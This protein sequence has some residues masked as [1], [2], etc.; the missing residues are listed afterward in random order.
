MLV[1]TPEGEKDVQILKPNS[2]EYDV[3]P[4]NYIVPEGEEGQ[5]HA[6]VEIK[7]FSSVDGSR[8]SIPRIQKF[9]QKWF[10]DNGGKEALVRQG[11]DVIVLHDPKA[12]IAK[13]GKKLEAQKAE[14]AQ[15]AAEEKAAAAQAA[16]EAEDAA[17][18]E[19]ISA[20]VA[21][22]VAAALAA[23]SKPV[24]TKVVEKQT[25]TEVKTEK[26]ASKEEDKK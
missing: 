8:L 25:P 1:K 23:Q 22:G 13:N 5:F 24:A 18:Q 15:K 6:I 12:W 17:L 2:N 4:Q 21:E 20:L 10:A 26:Q 11:Y 19:K 7:H 14:A 3:T 16:K 9:G